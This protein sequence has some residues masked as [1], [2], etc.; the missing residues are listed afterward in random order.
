MAQAKTDKAFAQSVARIDSQALLSRPRVEV[1]SHEIVDRLRRCAPGTPGLMVAANRLTRDRRT[2]AHVDRAPLWDE[3]HTGQEDPVRRSRAGHAVA[4]KG[5]GGETGTEPDRRAYV[6]AHRASV[7]WASACS[8]WAKARGVAGD[9]D[10]RIAG[11]ADV[12]QQYLRAGLVDEFAPAISPVMFGDGRRL[13][14]A[15]S[16]EVGVELVEAIASP[17]VTHVRYAVPER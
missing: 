16:R 2:V 14:E 15:I 11:G 7:S 6:P 8:S 4:A 9:R 13:F 17:R 10:I 1:S 3:P 12:I 5:E